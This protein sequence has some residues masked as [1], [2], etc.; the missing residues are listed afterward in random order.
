MSYQGAVKE[1]KIFGDENVLKERDDKISTA[2]KF[3]YWS[4]I[5]RG[6]KGRKYWGYDVRKW[7]K[8]PYPISYP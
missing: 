8:A 5:S 1:W 3:A 2:P 7:V 4:A 6:K